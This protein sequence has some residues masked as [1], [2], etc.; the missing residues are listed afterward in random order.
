[1]G[2]LLIDLLADPASPLRRVLR[3]SDVF[4]V[5]LTCK[6]A[7]Q[8]I[9]HA[10][11]SKWGVLQAATDAAGGDHHIPVLRWCLRNDVLNVC[12]DDS[13]YWTV[14]EA[15]DADL[16]DEILARATC[17]DD[18]VLSVLGGAARRGHDALA[19]QLA[20]RVA[21]HD[22]SSLSVPY[23]KDAV[24]IGGALQT[25][26]FI[27]DDPVAWM[28][29]LPAALAK[30]RLPFVQWVLDGSAPDARGDQYLS[31]AATSG[32]V[33]LVA[34]LVDQGWPLDFRVGAGAAHSGSIELLQWLH[35]RGE[36]VSPI[37][38]F[39]AAS[40][41]H[42]DVLDW[43]VAHGCNCSSA[44][45]IAEAVRNATVPVVRW[46]LDHTDQEVDSLIVSLACCNVR[47][48]A[49]FEF[50]V[51]ERR[52][53]CVD[54]TECMRRAASNPAFDA[55]ILVERY[56]VPLHQSY[57]DHAIERRDVSRLRFALSHGVLLT[58]HHYARMMERCA[59]ALLAEAIRCHSVGGT[60]TDEDRQILQA[61]TARAVKLHPAVQQ[62][63]GANSVNVVA[64]T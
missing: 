18:S 37:A 12:T 2:L 58:V 47:G 53:D 5:R 61:A 24:A 62:M 9:R 1:M 57:V 44:D 4:C 15:G 41:S 21:R 8:S 23:L 26:K 55:A 35:D 36:A 19:V 6:E 63:L 50:L 27:D 59:V 7:W 42:P 33:E 30:G 51:T 10:P 39:A 34:W 14:G 17:P 13:L 49:V 31:E 38:T 25:A 54:P 52:V 20:H 3:L 32:S 40:S 64:A 22:R 45:L 29:Y 56:G 48:T 60:M 16:I 11:L 28:S 43:L 46:F